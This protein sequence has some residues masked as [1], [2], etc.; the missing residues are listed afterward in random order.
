MLWWGRLLLWVG[1]LGFLG[2]GIAFL[3]A[4]LAL[5]G[6][7][8]LPLSGALA[9]T[10]LMAFYGGL[11]VALGALVLACAVVPRR[12]RDGLVLMGTCYGGIGTAR[13]AGMLLTGASS[14][15]LWFALATEILFA[16]LGVALWRG[17]R[18][19]APSGC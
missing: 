12:V 11:E 7:I 9:T 17:L 5:Y 15:F 4:P 13:A 6:A 1:G 10:E 14:G 18:P 3:F 16:V 8:G 19:G 2:F